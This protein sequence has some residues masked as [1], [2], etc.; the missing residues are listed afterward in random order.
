M[1]QVWRVLDRYI[2]SA[3]ARGNGFFVVE[4]ETYADVILEKLSSV[5]G[6]SYE[7]E[8]FKEAFLSYRRLK[9]MGLIN[10]NILRHALREVFPY[11][12][13]PEKA[14]ELTTRLREL[15]GLKIPGYFPTPTRVVEKM[16]AGWLTRDIVEG[17][18]RPFLVLKPS[19]GSG[20]MA[21]VARSIHPGI[22][23]HCVEINYRL[24]EILKLKGHNLVADDFLE[25][26]PGPV[27]DA[28][29]INPPFE[30]DLDLEHVY[31]AW[32]CLKPGGLMFAIMSPTPFFGSARRY[33]EFREWYE[34]YLVSIETLESGT[35]KELGTDVANK[36]ITLSKPVEEE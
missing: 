10:V 30:D 33:E 20:N 25:Y 6:S 2:H 24:R 19:V 12:T 1:K 31:H 5:R 16:L 35:F 21:D 28:I 17:L 13:V 32:S 4:S 8:R 11:L 15:I 14:D 7:V 27:Y 29:V 26:R 23:V 36:I 22:E 9:R 3:R 18:D 34:Q